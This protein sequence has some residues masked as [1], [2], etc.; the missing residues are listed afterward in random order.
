[1]S[2]R[3]VGSIPPD[4]N[5]VKAAWTAAPGRGGAPVCDDGL[6]GQPPVLAQADLESHPSDGSVSALFKSLQQGQARLANTL[7][8]AVSRGLG[9]QADVA[10][11]A[12]VK[13]LA[14][15]IACEPP[16]WAA[17]SPRPGPTIGHSRCSTGANAA[18]RTGRCGRRTQI[19]DRE[20][21]R[22]R[23]RLIDGRFC[24]R[25]LLDLFE[26]SH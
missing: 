6:F 13:A 22:E 10:P 26:K 3:T 9:A 2:H 5:P 1:M 14:R 21:E 15:A 23:P 19:R 12:W 18:W 20:R 11:I 17:L 16:D 4:S 7:R 25:Y 8:Q 24:I